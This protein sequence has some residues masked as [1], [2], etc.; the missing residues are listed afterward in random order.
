MRG[1]LI[2][3][4]VDFILNSI[5]LDIERYQVVDFSFPY[6]VE[7]FSIV[8][9]EP[10]EE[11]KTLTILRPFSPVVWLLLGANIAAGAGTF[12]F[13]KALSPYRCPI[14]EAWVVTLSQPVEGIRH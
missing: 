10:K 2:D 7:Y 5:S 12:R 4:Q 11:P 8:T 9:A 14:V 1:M 3:R 13:L 6:D